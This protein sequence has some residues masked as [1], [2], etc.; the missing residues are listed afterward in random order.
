[1]GRED[2]VTA[3]RLGELSTYS[4]DI[5]RGNDLDSCPTQ[6]DFELPMQLSFRRFR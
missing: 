2:H 1:M 4:I 5:H 6:P 3:K